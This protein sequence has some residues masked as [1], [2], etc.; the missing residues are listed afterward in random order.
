MLNSN[1]KVYKQISDAIIQ[2]I[3]EL[4]NRISI[5]KFNLEYKALNEEQKSQINEIYPHKFVEKMQ[6]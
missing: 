5:E 4:R 3:A 6:E 1:L 2:E